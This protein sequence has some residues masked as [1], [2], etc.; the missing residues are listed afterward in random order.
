MLELIRALE[1]KVNA[2]IWEIED[3][4]EFARAVM[5]KGANQIAMDSIEFAARRARPAGRRCFR[6]S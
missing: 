1:S 4:D 2:R 5:V 6:S 3:S